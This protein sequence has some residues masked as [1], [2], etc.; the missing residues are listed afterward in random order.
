MNIDFLHALDDII[1]DKGISKEVLIDALE[2]AL[3]SA[4]KK[5]YGSKEN[6]R[7]E[8][9]DNDGDVKVFQQ[10]KVVEEIERERFEVSLEEARRKDKSYQVGD[11]MEI[12][13]TPADFGRIAAQT[14]KQVIMQRIREAERDVIFEE[15]KQ[16]EA[17]IIT[18]S[19]HR[20]HKDNVLIDLGKTEALL[21]PSEQIPGEEYQTGKRIKLYVVEVASTTKGP[22]ILVSRTHPGLLK[23]L[24]ELE[25]P[26]IFD[27]IVTIEA[28]ARE[29][30]Q[31]SKMAVSSTNENVDPVGACVG[32]QGMRVK[33]VVEELNGEKI[34]IIEWREDPAELIANAVNPADVMQVNTDQ[35]GQEAEVVVPDFQLSLAIGKQGQNARLAAKL[36][37]WK[38][39]IIKETEYEE[40]KKAVEEAN[41]DEEAQA[42]NEGE[43]A[44]QETQT[45]DEELEDNVEEDDS[46]A[47]GESEE[48][49]QEDLL[50]EDTVDDVD[51][52][53]DQDV[54][55]DE[56]L[57]QK[58]EV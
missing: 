6:V 2:T 43:S 23:R 52:N 39:D 19:I 57:E 21:P 35:Q 56:Q 20:F 49:T 24:F 42:K 55:H 30:G 22:R 5:D 48:Q 53:A 11:I 31:R 58:E 1:K 41:K 25:V 44:S 47:K 28:V 14:A 10:K 38:I 7:V 32:P 26:E 51:E 12:E 37:G 13:V 27:G 8:I 4:Y 46:Q 36:T 54:N 17:E 18:G 15:Y 34:D 50:K 45:A 16:K 29:A 3:L 40:K 33:E 9:S